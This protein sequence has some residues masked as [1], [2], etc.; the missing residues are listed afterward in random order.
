MG[1]HPFIAQWS[2]DVW[3][4]FG[5]HGCEGAAGAAPMAAQ[6]RE[7]DRNTKISKRTGSV[8][9]LLA[10]VFAAVAIAL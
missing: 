6:A 8:L 2:G 5:Q 7:A 4:D 1:M 3:P 10:I 9:G